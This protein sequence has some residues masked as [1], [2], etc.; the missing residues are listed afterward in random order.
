VSV[1]LTKADLED[2]RL[3]TKADVAALKARLTWRLV[4]MTGVCVGAVT[5]LKVC[6]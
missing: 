2:L 4:L 5:A 3:T 6:A 1:L